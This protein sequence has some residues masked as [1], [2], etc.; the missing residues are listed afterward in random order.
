M[1]SI[2]CRRCVFLRKVLQF[3]IPGLSSHASV[4]GRINKIVIRVSTLF[5]M[6]LP[7]IL[8]FDVTKIGEILEKG[9]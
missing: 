5:F 1:K 3:S 6:S 2:D 9:G 4:Q 8:N 7:Q